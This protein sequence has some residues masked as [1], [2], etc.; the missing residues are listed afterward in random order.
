MIY[1]S[2]AKNIIFEFIPA[3]KVTHGIVILCDGLPGVPKQKKLMNNMANSGF[4]V[5]FVRYAGTWESEGEFLKNSPTSDIEEVLH[6]IKG[7]VIVELYA[8]KEF[9]VTGLPIY[10]V[11]S[12]FGGSV[13]LSLINNMDISKIIA[14]SPIVDLSTHNDAGSEQDLFWLGNFVKQAFGKG[15]RFEDAQWKRMAEGKLFNPPQ[16]V[17][18][19]RAH[20][21]L[22][23]YGAEDSEIDPKKIEKYAAENG[24]KT[25]SDQNQGHLSFSK[26]SE[27]MWDKIFNWLIEK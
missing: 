8:N 27:K 17:D 15:Y 13:A 20:D 7:G 22:L 9:D 26:I 24:I 10:L 18:S 6:L 19:K 11:G 4:F 3:K 25:I 16:N 23:V 1:R 5:V 2:K 12:S 21:I 14:F